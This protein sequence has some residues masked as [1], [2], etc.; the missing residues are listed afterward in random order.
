MDYKSLSSRIIFGEWPVKQPPV[1]H[2][3]KNSQDRSIFITIFLAKVKE[4]ISSD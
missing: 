1:S 3:Q 4:W 2:A